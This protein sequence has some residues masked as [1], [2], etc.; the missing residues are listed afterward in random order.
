MSLL[1]SVTSTSWPSLCCGCDT[2]GL[3]LSYPI[4]WYHTLWKEDSNSCVGLAHRNWILLEF[5]LFHL[6]ELL[7]TKHG[8]HASSSQTT[9]W[10]Q[11]PLTP[12]GHVTAKTKDQGYT[13]IQKQTCAASKFLHFSPF[14]PSLVWRG[15]PSC[16]WQRWGHSSW[17]G[18]A[19]PRAGQGFRHQPSPTMAVALPLSPQ[20]GFQSGWLWVLERLAQ[21]RDKDFEK[22]IREEDIRKGIFHIQRAETIEKKICQSQRDEFHGLWEKKTQENRK[23]CAGNQ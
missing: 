20:N 18:S 10:I 23:G 21:A 6:A 7:T 4:T 12:D 9:F 8:N 17:S 14:P 3:A 15:G 11:F 2:A 5:G 19:S 22:H 1:L 13:S 16:A